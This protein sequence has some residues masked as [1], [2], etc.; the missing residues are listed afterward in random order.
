MDFLEGDWA[1]KEA[2]RIR[3]PK[4]IG[5]RGGDYYPNGQSSFITLASPMYWYCFET[6]K[7][8]IGDWSHHMRFAHYVVLP[9]GC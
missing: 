3:R 4:H 6:T 9:A 2:P 5:Y 7:E 8:C 1:A